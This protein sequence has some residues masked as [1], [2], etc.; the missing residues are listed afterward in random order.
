M[1]SLA[2][3]L[4]LGFLP[5]AALAATKADIEAG[6]KIA[7]TTS[8]GNCDACHMFAGADEAGNIGPELKDVKTMIPDRKIFY[9]IIYDEPARNPR[10]LMPP[11]GRNAILTPKQI[12][13]VIDFMYTK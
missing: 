10:T 11:F 8:L 1:K 5:V 9:A 7:T 13:D 12:N 6:R 2:I 3:A 4:V